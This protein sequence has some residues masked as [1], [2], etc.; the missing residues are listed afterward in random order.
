MAFSRNYFWGHVFYGTTE[1]I[2]FLLFQSFLA[3]SEIRQGNVAIGV[4]QD[5][6]R[7]QNLHFRKMDIEGGRIASILFDLYSRM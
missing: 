5:T 6:K 4:Q 7:L 2:G 1:R 3:Q